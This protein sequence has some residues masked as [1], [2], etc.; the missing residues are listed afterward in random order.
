MGQLFFQQELTR[1]H[2]QALL[3]EA[4][5]YRLLKLIRAGQREQ[6]I[7]HLLRR[8]T[9]NLSTGIGQL[10]THVQRVKLKQSNGRVERQ[11]TL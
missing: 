4:N 10:R 8:L 5:N 6:P 3:Q 7:T 11:L 1:Q 9:A 2:R